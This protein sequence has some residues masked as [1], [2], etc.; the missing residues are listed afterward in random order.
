MDLKEEAQQ[1]AR[2]AKK[3]E[4][5]FKEIWMPEGVMLCCYDTLPGTIMPHVII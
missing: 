3:G 4:V 2:E 5:C 1:S